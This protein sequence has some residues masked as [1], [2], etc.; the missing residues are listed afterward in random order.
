MK[1][2][3][4][5]SFFYVLGISNFLNAAPND[6]YKPPKLPGEENEIVIKKHPFANKIQSDSMFSAKSILTPPQN[7]KSNASVTLT[8]Y[9]NGICLV[10]D[11]RYVPVVAGINKVNFP[12]IYR[13]L[14]KDSLNFRS[15]KQGKLVILDYKLNEQDTSRHNLFAS[16]V[17]NTVY[18]RLDNQKIEK[19][20]LIG[21]SKEKNETFV[22]I[23]TENKCFIIPISCCLA[24]DNNICQRIASNSVDVTFES[25]T[26]DNS[27]IEI[28]YLTK[29]IHWKHLCVIDVFEK[30]D[31]V[32][33][34]S[35]ALLINE[36]GYD[37]KNINV[38]FSTTSP[39]FEKIQKETNVVFEKN[40][41][42]NLK[43][44]EFSQNNLNAPKGASLICML[45]AAK[46]IKP[47]LEYIVK[48][49]NFVF[50][51]SFSDAKNIAVGNL[52]IIE[53]AK[54]LD[55]GKSLHD[56]EALIFKR[57]N[58]KVHFLGTQ[59]ISSLKKDD[60]MVFEIGTTSDI[61]AKI[62]QTDVRKLSEQQAEYAIRVHLKNYKKTEA[63]AVIIADVHS[64]WSIAK[65]HV[66]MRPGAKPSW[67]IKLKPEESK[68]LHFRIRI[69][70]KQR[71]K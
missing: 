29:N 38:I 21:L 69:A 25:K 4:L 15:I 50:K 41:S 17:G 44:L 45:K 58:E 16:A 65:K 1:F 13:G 70:T 56:S 57:T 61:A 20:K 66:D 7:S 37:L 53:N 5:V 49:P 40:H 28:S 10:R 6:D 18:Y 63:M 23:E 11:V 33:I 32:D 43:A 48:I 59:M 52:L 30:L 19:G 47:K 42:S 14:I 64:P 39:N 46:E 67:Y 9:K 68:E 71:K 2:L 8:C 55:L 35:K 3:S 24:V 36:S 51:E 26:S 22:T 60:D 34:F 62:E 12:G 54:S 27:E 31:R